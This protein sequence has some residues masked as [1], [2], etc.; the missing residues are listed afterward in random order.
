MVLIDEAPFGLE[1]TVMVVLCCDDNRYP[2]HVWEAGN[3]FW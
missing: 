1:S 2:I 3:R